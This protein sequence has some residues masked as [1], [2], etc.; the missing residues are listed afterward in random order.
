MKATLQ[1]TRTGM[2]SQRREEQGAL[3]GVERNPKEKGRRECRVKEGR[4]KV[5]CLVWSGSRRRRDDDN[6]RL[7]S[8]RRPRSEKGD[9]GGRLVCVVKGEGGDERR[10]R[11]R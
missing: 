8:Q 10:L 9:N 5:P 6:S 1:Y 11:S 3:L 4:S 7:F 2:A